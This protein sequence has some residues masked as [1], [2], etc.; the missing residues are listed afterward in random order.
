MDNRGDWR[1]HG[2]VLTLSYP[3]W[4][5]MNSVTAK[6]PL[7]TACTYDN[8]CCRWTCQRAPGSSTSTSSWRSR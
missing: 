1:M 8:H 5:N 7:N 4:H 6:Q 3:T 2:L